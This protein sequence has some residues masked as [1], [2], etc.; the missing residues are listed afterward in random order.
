[1]VEEDAKERWAAGAFLVCGMPGAAAS[2]AVGC[3]W[4][5]PRL[6]PAKGAQ[7]TFP[8]EVQGRPF[9]LGENCSKDV[10]ALQ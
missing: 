6:L 7:E 5:L 9:S 10:T 1:M 3:F 4:G 8:S 2:G